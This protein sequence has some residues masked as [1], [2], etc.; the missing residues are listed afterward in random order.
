MR[1][2]KEETTNQPEELLEQELNM[3]KTEEQI[4]QV[5]PIEEFGKLFTIFS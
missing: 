2:K 1:K 4:N 5:D 3:G